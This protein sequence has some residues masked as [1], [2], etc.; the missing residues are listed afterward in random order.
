MGTIKHQ[1]NDKYE[2]DNDIKWFL[3][4]DL[5][6]LGEQEEI[7]K[8]YSKNIRNEYIH[9]QSPVF[10][11]K[12]AEVMHKFLDRKQLYFSNEFK[13]QFEKMAR[14]NVGNEIQTLQKSMN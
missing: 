13:Q 12:R 5:A 11:Q 4:F 6:I 8:T 3:D 1:I 7:Y 2:D 10:E 9:V 14:Q